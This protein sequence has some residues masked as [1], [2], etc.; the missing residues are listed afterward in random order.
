MGCGASSSKKRDEK[1]GNNNAAN[2]KNN[3]ATVRPMNAVVPGTPMGVKG[4]SAPKD[5]NKNIARVSPTRSLAG[6]KLK[7]TMSL[8][9]Q[10]TGY[11]GLARSKLVRSMIVKLF[12]DA[13]KDQDG[14]IDHT[15]LRKLYEEVTMRHENA[16]SFSTS[17]AKALMENMDRKQDPSILMEFEFVGSCMREMGV[18][19]SGNIESR[20]FSALQ[21]LVFCIVEKVENM[22]IALHMLFGKYANDDKLLTKRSMK[23]LLGDVSK[24]EDDKPSKD[25]IDVFV[26]FMDKDGDG[27]IE[28][29]EFVSYMSRGFTQ[30]KM[31]IDAFCRRSSMHRKIYSFLFNI[32]H[33]MDERQDEILKLRVELNEDMKAKLMSMAVS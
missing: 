24:D 15:E 18:L 31:N 30:P 23:K 1:G 22:S 7:P 19:D 11:K 12:K 28:E 4:K 27:S 8:S 25:E 33:S 29:K 20:E 10:P 6:A 13:D 17:D 32:E 26:N 14:R 16:D 2:G 21:L 3:S 9:R 5:D